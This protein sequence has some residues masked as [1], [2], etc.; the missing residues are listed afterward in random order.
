M[1]NGQ[2]NI[3]SSKLDLSTE[4]PEHKKI[5]INPSLK[6]DL[7]NDL[8]NDNV[9]IKSPELDTNFLAYLNSLNIQTSDIPLLNHNISISDELQCW[10]Q[11]TFGQSDTPY[12]SDQVAAVDAG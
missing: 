3:N 9:N 1:I 11:N 5:D 6:L 4:N 12:L 2:D 10:G 7:S 8:Q